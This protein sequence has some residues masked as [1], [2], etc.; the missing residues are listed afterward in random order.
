VNERRRNISY[1]I[2]NFSPVRV[3]FIIEQ[4]RPQGG[5][6]DRGAGLQPLSQIEIKNTDFIDQVMSN[7]LRD[8]SAE[9]IRWN[10]PGPRTL[11]FWKM[12]TWVY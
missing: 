5:G 6:G 10:R 2:L 9:I 1:L 4:G 8:L 12:K 3:D 11:E 7:V